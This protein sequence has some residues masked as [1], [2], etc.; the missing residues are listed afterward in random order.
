MKDKK[1]IDE[2]QGSKGSL[3]KLVAIS[4]VIIICMALFYLVIYDKPDDIT[5]N[6]FDMGMHFPRDEGSHEQ[7]VEIWTFSGFIRT[8]RGHSFGYQVSYYNTGIRS[9]TFIDEDNATGQKY[10]TTRDYADDSRHPDLNIIASNESLDLTYKNGLI[11]DVWQ[12]VGSSR[13]DLDS[14][15]Y[16]N[17]Q[18]LVRFNMTLQSQ[19]PHI[20][21]GDE[22]GISV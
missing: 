2:K 22:N 19:K 5:T 4:C 10:Y 18:E 3:K 16:D 12:T 8:T 1:K 14:V 13:Y 11:K 20:L 9:V 17:S 6:G 7:M 21:L 15:M